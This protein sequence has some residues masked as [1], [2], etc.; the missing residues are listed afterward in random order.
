MGADKAQPENA[1][2]A[3]NA[4]IV[5][6]VQRAQTGDLA[7][8]EQLFNHYQR[9]I[10]NLV[11]QMVRNDSDAADITQ[12]AFIRAWKALPRLQ[13]PEAFGSWLYRVATNLAR[14]W[15]RDHGRVRTESL[16]QPFSED[17]EGGQRDI[18]DTTKDPAQTLQTSD[19]K[20]VVQKAIMTLSEDHRAV[21]TLHHIEGMSVEEIA[22]IMNCSVGT[23]KSRLS[24]ARDH[25]RRK[26]AGYV[27]A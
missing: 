7:A 14:N 6:L 19:M 5:A 4:Q 25:L 23:V 15:I 27:E 10:Y 18:A 17:E 26:L 9:G 1:Q 8:F 21:V 16:D 2:N 13:A 22:G 3:Q 12:D 24:R 20:D 11:F